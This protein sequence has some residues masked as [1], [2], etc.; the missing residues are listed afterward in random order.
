MSK[1]NNIIEQLELP[2]LGLKPRRL[3]DAGRI[4][5]IVS[6][7]NRYR[8]AKLEIP[9]EWTEEYNDLVNTPMIV[10]IQGELKAG[11]IVINTIE[12]LRT[13][14]IEELVKQHIDGLLYDLN[15]TEPEIL[16]SK[17]LNLINNYAIFNV[18]KLLHKKCNEVKRK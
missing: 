15:L 9:K 3:H 2:P 17:S 6:A 12:G 10:T 11:N 14:N 18:I 13:C 1:Q 16:A 8:E 4:K 5:D 7:I